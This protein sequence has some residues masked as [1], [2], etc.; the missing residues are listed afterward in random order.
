MARIEI[1]AKK[2]R[3]KNV[4]YSSLTDSSETLILTMFQFAAKVKANVKKVFP[5]VKR[6]ELDEDYF[7]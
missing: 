6:S 2:H 7:E 3:I 4:G 1:A 5:N